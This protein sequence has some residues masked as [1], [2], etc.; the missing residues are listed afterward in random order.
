MERTGQD[1]VDEF[2]IDPNDGHAY[3]K[4]DFVNHYGSFKQWNAAKPAPAATHGEGRRDGAVEVRLLEKRLSAEKKV[5][6]EVGLSAGGGRNARLSKSL[7]DVLK[8]RR[9][10]LEKNKAKA[11]TQEYNMVA[12]RTVAGPEVASPAT[13][14]SDAEAQK[15]VRKKAIASMEENSK[16]ISDAIKFDPT[17][18]TRGTDGT[19]A[20][21]SSLG[22]HGLV[23]EALDEPKSAP[24][25]AYSPVF[26]LAKA[27][28]EKGVAKG[29]VSKAAA[30]FSAPKSGFGS[31]NLG[32]PK[33]APRQA[34]SPV[35]GP[36]KAAAEKGVAN[37]GVSKAAAAFSAPTSGFGSKKKTLGIRRDGST[38]QKMPPPDRV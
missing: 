28:A 36:A 16:E 32:N 10:T 38:Y 14:V 8:D 3:T 29:G 35:F 26:G 6:G 21:S 37:G 23:A 19:A 31:K 30:A 25:R 27:A 18:S 9:R 15:E 24:R 1:R 11:A 4:N 2:R 7:V 22:A 17:S 12:S 5:K 34:Y 33:S 13:A 20:Q